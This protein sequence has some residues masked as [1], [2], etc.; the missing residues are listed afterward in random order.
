MNHVT[1]DY[2]LIDSGN[3]RK[4]ERFGSILLSRPSASAVWAPA[5]P[6]S[7]WEQANASFDRDGGN[8]WSFRKTLPDSWN[9]SVEGILFKL[10]IT[11]FGHLGIFP[12]QAASW[13]WIQNIIRNSIPQ[14]KERISVLNLFAYSG[15]STLAAARAGAEV[16][17]L[18]ASKGMVARARENAQI[19]GLDKAP[20]RW[21]V[22]DVNKFLDREARR[23]SRYDAIILD[24]PSFGRGKSGEVYKIEKDILVTLGKCTRLLSNNPLFLLLSCHTPAFTPVVMNNLLKQAM[25]KHEGIIESGEMLLRGSKNVLPIPSG[26]FASWRTADQNHSS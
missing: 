13:K 26:T 10:S 20:I 24:P 17:H 3:E 21:I 16:C 8:S 6:S 9:I 15:G 18:D 22:E 1:N 23:N 5:L 7:S 4:L 12:E 2:E 11:N 25:N 19:N 14:R